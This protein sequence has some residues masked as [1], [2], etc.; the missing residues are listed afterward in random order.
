MLDLKKIKKESIIKIVNKKFDKIIYLLILDN[1]VVGHI[2]H[3]F[4]L[5]NTHNCLLHL[6]HHNRM[7]TLYDQTLQYFIIDREISNIE[8][9]T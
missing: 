5:N 2:T 7:T 9:I 8:I 1:N 4:C 6:S 3:C